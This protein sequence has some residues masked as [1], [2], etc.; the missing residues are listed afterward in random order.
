MTEKCARP[1]CDNELKH[2][3]GRKRKKYCSRECKLRH[4]QQLNPVKKDKKYVKVPI[5]DYEKYQNVISKIDAKA[6]DTHESEKLLHDSAKKLAPK[7]INAPIET[8]ENL[9]NVD[10]T[11]IRKQI[12]LIQ[13]EKIPKERDTYNGRKTWKIDQDNKIKELREKLNTK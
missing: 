4:W 12:A 11:E 13:A 9:V 10:E 1:Q 2:I 3:E 5:E 8:L 6:G 7:T